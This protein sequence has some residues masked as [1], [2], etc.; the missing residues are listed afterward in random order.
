M[1]I[2]SKPAGTQAGQLRDPRDGVHRGL[3]DRGRAETGGEADALGQQAAVID[4]DRI[5]LRP[6][7]V[8]PESHDP[9][10]DR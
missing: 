6:T 4:G 2:E 5:R 10:P 3:D 9:D 7:D 1:P 8:D